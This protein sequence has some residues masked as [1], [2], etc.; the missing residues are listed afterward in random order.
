M[1]WD[2]FLKVAVP[3]Y[4][5]KD[6]NVSL[7]WR[8]DLSAN[9]VSYERCMLAIDCFASPELRQ[10]LK[11]SLVVP[12]SPA[13]SSNGSKNFT[14]SEKSIMVG[15]GIMAMRGLIMGVEETKSRLVEGTTFESLSPDTY[16]NQECLSIAKSPPSRISGK[17]FGA[18]KGSV[19]TLLQTMG[20]EINNSQKIAIEA[21]FNQRTTL[22]QGPPGTGKTRTLVRL[23][24]AFCRSK[25]G[26]VL[27]C[28]DR[29]VM[30]TWLNKSYIYN[31]LIK[32][33]LPILVK[34]FVP[35]AGKQLLLYVSCK[36]GAFQGF[37]TSFPNR[38]CR[39][40]CCIF[41]SLCIWL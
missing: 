32:A 20:N 18:H 19:R 1:A 33:C 17:M 28:A 4:Q 26:Q 21:A 30:F 16:I 40:M 23:I 8:L 12:T 39:I 35:L 10:G 27:A 22:W 14:K 31:F 7:K 2:R 6:L 25:Q 38:T 15:E 11:G 41:M 5:A 9:R 29:Y 24:T 37:W 34:F 3:S 13:A 36:A